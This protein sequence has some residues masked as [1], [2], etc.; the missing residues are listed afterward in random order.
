MKVL[1][2]LADGM[3]PD[4]FANLPKAQEIVLTRNTPGAVLQTEL[5]SRTL[6]VHCGPAD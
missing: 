3:R 1:L 4:S 2:I 5:T 6:L